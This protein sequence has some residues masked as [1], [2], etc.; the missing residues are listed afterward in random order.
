MS[1]VR[2]L[3]ILV[4][5]IPLGGLRAQ[6]CA[7]LPTCV[8]NSG[9]EAEAGNDMNIGEPYDVDG[10]SVSHG[11]PSIFANDAPSDDSGS[12][13][14]MWSYSGQGEGIT[15]CLD[16]RAGV[17]YEVCMWV[18]NTNTVAQD[19]RLQVWLVDEVTP[20]PDNPFVLSPSLLDGELVDS[21]WV[22]DTEWTQVTATVTPAVDRTR[23]LIFPYMSSPLQNGQLQYELQVDD[24]R[25][26]PVLTAAN[27]TL[28]IDATRD[29]IG[30]CDS[31]AMCITG[32]P[33]NVEVEWSP[34]TGLSS[35]SGGCATASP[36]S[37][38]TYTATVSVPASCPN[39]CSPTVLIDPLRITIEVDPPTVEFTTL[40]PVLC[41]TEQVIIA[42]LPD[43]TCATGVGWRRAP[44]TTAQ[45]DSLIIAELSS[46]SSGP[47]VYE[48]IHPGGACM[49]TGGRVVLHPQ[50]TVA[51]VYMPNAFSPNG[52]GFNDVFT[53]TSLGFEH[54]ELTVYDRWGR[55]VH[56]T[57]DA[58]A[59]WD[60]SSNG[61][62]VPNGVY[63]YVLEHTLAC[64]SDRDR[65]VGHVTL[66]R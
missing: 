53:G 1:T 22:N 27:L 6:P 33:A 32:A 48:V 18:R 39:S 19:G 49:A 35:V 25:V 56:T 64:S 9:L 17:E 38:T 46:E 7:V 24:V 43:G 23:L 60:G 47:Y 16:L 34:V 51:E 57:S 30:W 26:T 37:T 11:N 42:S 55:A 44:G 40:G 14:W 54:F 15:T 20:S 65:V 2:A 12:S 52:D 62:W 58:S 36:C 13:I 63:A 5:L 21:S 50:G 45:G 4:A 8:V 29:R 28:G 61:Q 66:L 59:G 31:T 41:G 3:S 10:W